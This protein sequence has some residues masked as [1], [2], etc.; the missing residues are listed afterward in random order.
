ML[1]AL[2]QQLTDATSSD[3]PRLSPFQRA[4]GVVRHRVGPLLRSSDRPITTRSRRYILV[5]RPLHQLPAGPDDTSPLCNK[6]NSQP[7]PNRAE[8]TSPLGQRQ[9][10]ARALSQHDALGVDIDLGIAIKHDELTM[11]EGEQQLHF[12]ARRKNTCV[13]LHAGIIP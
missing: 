7:A 1:H 5:I 8:Q 12:G 10:R 3:S 6:Q 11:I 4:H 2:Q 9:P 13:W